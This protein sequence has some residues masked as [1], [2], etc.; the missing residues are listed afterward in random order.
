M[1][2]TAALLSFALVLSGCTMRLMPG[3]GSS[4]KELAA[5]TPQCHP[6]QYWDGDRCV[7]KGKGHGARKHD[8]QA[9]R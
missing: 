6:S 5:S 2:R 1:S 9:R 8:G 4:R 3:H 7:H